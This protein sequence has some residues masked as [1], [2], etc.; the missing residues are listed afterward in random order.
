MDEKPTLEK[1]SIEGFLEYLRKHKENRGVMADLRHGFSQATEYRAW[2]H[3]ARWCDLGNDRSR[4]IM[5]TVAAGFAIHGRSVPSGN[6]GSVFRKIATGD[7]RG[8]EGLATFDARFRRF[9]S[10]STALEVCDHLPGVL[11]AVERKGAPVDFARLHRDLTFWG[12]RT[13]VEWA[14]D[15]WG[16]PHDQEPAAAEQVTP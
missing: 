11:R 3:I 14:R 16:A 13:K 7:G 2:P 12:E 9:L 1:N 10:C 8:Q 5:L 4:R 15:Y 6:L